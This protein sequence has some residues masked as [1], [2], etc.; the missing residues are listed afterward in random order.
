MPVVSVAEIIL[1]CKC[2]LETF[3]K[4]K[5]ESAIYSHTSGSNSE[6]QCHIRIEFQLADCLDYIR[7]P[8]QILIKDCFYDISG[9]PVIKR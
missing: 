1:L 2:N 6:F 5:A 7:N 9:S 4:D 3:R 8:S